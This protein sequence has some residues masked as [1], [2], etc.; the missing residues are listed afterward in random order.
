M[1]RTEAILS[2]LLALL[3]L[4]GCA[5]PG[6]PAAHPAA[7][8]SEDAVSLDWYVNYSWFSGP[9]GTNTVSR[10]ITD[11][12]GVKVDFLTPIGSEQEK[13]DALIAQGNLPDLITLGWWEP[14]VQQLIASGDVYALNELADRYAPSFYDAAGT[15][16]LR[17][18]TQNDGNVYCYPNCS[19]S[20]EDYAAGAV[21]ASNET[22]L[23]RKDLYEALGSPDM[24]TPEGFSDALRRAVLLCPQV[25]GEPL[26]PFG[27]SEFN[28][29]GCD[30]LG[31]MLMNFLAVPFE[32][33]GKSYDRVTD[34]EYLRWL[35]TFRRLFQDGYLTGQL[36]ID[37]RVQMAERIQRGQYFCMLY[38]YSDLADQ[39]KA[40]W[41]TDPDGIYI[42][43][44]GPR[45]SRRDAPT[46]PSVGINGW[47][48]TF[49]SKNCKDPEAAIRLLSYMLTPE[50]QKL[51][52]LGREE[53]NYT[54]DGGYAALTE[55]TKDL[56]FG[57]YA[58]YVQ[59][60]GAN[61]T[62]WMLEDLAMQSQWPLE[63][64]SALTQ[65]QQWAQQYT[66]YGAP[67]EI[68]SA[69]SGELTA[70]DENCKKLWGDTLPQLLMAESDEA[71][72]RLF[73]SYLARRETL[74]YGA[75]LEDQTACIQSNKDRLGME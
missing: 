6:A 64:P 44:D 9:W 15:E 27:T 39:Q 11:K 18:Y 28:E 37:K 52:Y 14:Q 20:P 16:Q 12:T 19:V 13:L 73:A 70:I 31:G 49:I 60:V 47:T 40:R 67:Y 68:G 45:N 74:G 4:G 63:M 30:S 33:D 5:A 42:A 36:F 21:P 56:Y 8:N 38:Q 59:K 3:L 35:K 43:V 57:D 46:L 26:I 23:V 41:R 62:Y 22:F 61:N 32:K 65:P 72:D 34:P 24:T 1:K 71:F 10:A 69:G 2:L 54:W 29:Y 75:V 58:A 7:Q 55:G 53:E 51:I 66:F 25:E 17:W 50:C 48:V